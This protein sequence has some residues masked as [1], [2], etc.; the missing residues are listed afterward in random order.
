MSREQVE[1][2]NRLL[3]SL[4]EVMESVDN[5][6]SSLDETDIDSYHADGDTYVSKT[7]RFCAALKVLQ[8]N[9]KAYSILKMRI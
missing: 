3:T 1:A 7:E 2:T 4:D 8:D 5:F 9:Y 6:L